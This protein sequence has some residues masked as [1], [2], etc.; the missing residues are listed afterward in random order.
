M[1][2]RQAY[3]I[4]VQRTGAPFHTFVVLIIAAGLAYIS[5]VPVLDWKSLQSKTHYYVTNKR[6]ILLS[7]KNLYALCRAGLN[8]KC[9]ETD[10]GL[11]IL[12]GAS[13]TK[14]A[15]SWRRYTVVPDPQSAPGFVF[16]GIDVGK[17]RLKDILSL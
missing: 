7:N 8:M 12:F 4:A 6:V 5:L 2:K 10:A 13:I 3:Y 9:I 1:Y 15:R 17:D 11:H 14:S 16:Y